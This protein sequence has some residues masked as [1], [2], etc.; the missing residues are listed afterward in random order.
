MDWNMALNLEG[1]PTYVKNFVDSPIIVNTTADE[2]Y[3]QPMYY[4][5]GH[6][7]KYLRPGA[8]RVQSVYTG[9]KAS[10]KQTVFVNS[11]GSV[12]IS[13]FNP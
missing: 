12:V 8:Q 3:K 4:A 10:I 6:F 5:L 11:D 13:I 9:D 7:S 1:G 2:F